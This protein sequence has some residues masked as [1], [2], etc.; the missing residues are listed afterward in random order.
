M[1]GLPVAPTA[2]DSAIACFAQA[3]TLSPTDTS[4]IPSGLENRCPERDP[5]FESPPL[6]HSP[7]ARRRTR[8]HRIEEDEEV[9]S[10]AAPRFQRIGSHRTERRRAGRASVSAIGPRR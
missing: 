7:A 4:A 10:Q 6:R 2:I 1:I 3:A 8:A 5:G 9:G